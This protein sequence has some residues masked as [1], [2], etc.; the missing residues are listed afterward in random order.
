MRNEFAKTDQTQEFL[1]DTLKHMEFVRDSLGIDIK[2]KG[3]TKDNPSI[4]EIENF[5]D[6]TRI[7]IENTCIFYYLFKPKKLLNAFW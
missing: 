7:E 1:I 5:Q 4:S 2:F 3:K 6:E